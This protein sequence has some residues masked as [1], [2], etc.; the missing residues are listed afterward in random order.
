MAKIHFVAGFGVMVTWCGRSVRGVHHLQKT[1]TPA[2]VTCKRC[3]AGMPEAPQRKRK[4]EQVWQ[5][6]WERLRV[7]DENF[8]GLPAVMDGIEDSIK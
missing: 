5:K 3:L 1:T 4:K 2:K 7:L 8:A 6:R